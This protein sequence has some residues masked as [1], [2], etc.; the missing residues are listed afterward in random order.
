M[1]VVAKCKCGRWLIVPYRQ[2][3]RLCPYCG[4]RVRLKGRYRVFKRLIDAQYFIAWQYG[5]RT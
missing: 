3:S 1:Y 4:R 2:K 5:I